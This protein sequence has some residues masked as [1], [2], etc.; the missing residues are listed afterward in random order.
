MILSILSP[1]IDINNNKLKK[2]EIDCEIRF[3]P[4]CKYD[5]NYGISKISIGYQNLFYRSSY[6]CSGGTLK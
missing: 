5:C 4:S 6:G 2:E 1:L 3:Y